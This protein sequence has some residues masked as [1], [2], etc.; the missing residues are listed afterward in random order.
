MYVLEVEAV[1]HKATHIPATVPDY[2]DNEANHHQ[3]YKEEG[4]CKANCQAGRIIR[5]GCKEV[6]T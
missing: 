3:Y 6:T 4:K 5:L 1:M 2:S